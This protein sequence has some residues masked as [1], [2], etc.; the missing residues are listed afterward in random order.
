[1]P[2]RKQTTR[3]ELATGAVGVA[4]GT[5]SYL[6][7]D[8][9]L[10]RPDVFPQVFADVM[11]QVSAWGVVGGMAI[12]AGTIGGA[13]WR[14]SR[15]A[16]YREL[17]RAEGWAD[18]HDFADTI[19]S[20]AIR[21][22]GPQTRPSL[23]DKDNPPIGRVIK[24]T[25]YGQRIGKCVTGA[26][27]VRGRGVYASFEE[28]LL[29]IAPPG[30]GKTAL[31]LHMLLDAP[32]AVLAASTKP[33]LVLLTR[34]LRAQRGPVLEFNPQRIG[35]LEGNF[36]W[37]PLI[38]CEDQQTAEARARAHVHGTKAI[39][40]MTEKSWS[41]KCIKIVAMYMMAARL[42]DHDMSA[43]AY[44]LSHPEIE[45]AVRILKHFGDVVPAGTWQALEAEMRS[46]ADR[47]KDSI[48]SLAREAV[49]Y[50][51]NPVVAAACA[52]GAGETFDV[53]EFVHSRGTL[54]L[55]GSDE[56]ESIAP[57]L[58]ALT[59]YI[60]SGMKAEALRQ[61][62]QRL[63][64][65]FG[66][67]LDE[68]SKITP[69]PLDK[70]ASDLRSHGGYITAVVQSRGQVRERWGD[71]GA[72]IIWD[73][74]S[75]VVL[76][77]LKNPDDLRDLAGLVGTRKVEV[78]SHGESEGRGGR[79]RSSN[80]SEREEQVLTP[81]QIRQLPKGHAL[82]VIGEANAAVVKYRK[83]QVRAERE[84]RKLRARLARQ[85]RSVDPVTAPNV[86]EVQFGD[87]LRIVPDPVE[88]GADQ[89]GEHKSGAA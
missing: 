8:T 10:T 16:K 31:I 2:M 70:W 28:S 26:R 33:D 5:G 79:S 29:V 86:H 81:N 20:K 25:D 62:G 38:G 43:V 75:L 53:A 48:W 6:L 4:L 82:V 30:K 42:A 44:W 32:G 22:L 40:A 77:G 17:F 56:D 34:E 14:R 12:T 58:N 41:E 65:P 57:L 47:M 78:V 15:T 73:L 76:R 1:M 27:R 83:G 66:F 84:L 64:P 19:G 71:I 68:A 37:N 39:M 11:E 69:V 24:P 9:P 85:Q 3:S 54:Y 46:K 36:R 88:Q 21:A 63:D 59:S 72:G 61:P 23:H 55:L 13:V 89:A 51:G 18:R 67:I 74:F 7:G 87:G 49:A 50:M 35:G 80:R 60:Y 45:E 52:K